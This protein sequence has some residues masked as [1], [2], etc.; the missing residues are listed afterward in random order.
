MSLPVCQLS[1]PGLANSVLGVKPSG[2]SSYV[3]KKIEFAS[4][5]RFLSR[6]KM[7]ILA[8]MLGTLWVSFS[9]SMV[10]GTGLCWCCVKERLRMF[11]P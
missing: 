7:A 11:R 2:R 6:G 9:L 3:Q 5:P 8:A 1:L 10:W 4:L